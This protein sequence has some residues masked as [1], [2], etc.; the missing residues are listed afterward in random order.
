M[1]KALGS[2]YFASVSTPTQALYLDPT[3]TSVLTIV[4][5]DFTNI[6]NQWD[7]AAASNGATCAK[8]T[9]AAN[10]SYTISINQ[11]TNVRFAEVFCKLVNL[12]LHQYLTL[13]L[14]LSTN[15]LLNLVNQSFKIN[16]GSQGRCQRHPTHPH[17]AS[18]PT[19]PRSYPA[20]NIT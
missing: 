3:S 7:A 6:L 18:L 17:R 12:Y 4:I 9:T 16:L 8:R 10:S 20:R 19:S 11:T 1:T 13:Y 2:D 14:Y 5:I 15:L